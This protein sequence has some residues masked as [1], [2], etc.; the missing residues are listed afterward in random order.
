MES[1]NKSIDTKSSPPNTSIFSDKNTIIIILLSLLLLSFLGINLI[2]NI[3]D[4][5]QWILN[6]I[7]YF[8]RP[9]LSDITFI[10]GTVINNSSELASDA[11]KTGIDIADGT[12]Q[13]VGDL[14]IKAG[15]DGP[16]EKVPLGE[17]KFINRNKKIDVAINQPSS[18]KTSSPSSDSTTN[19]I[20]K[21][22]SSNKAGWC[23]IDE[24]EGQRNCVS[25][26][27]HEKCMSGQIFQNQQMCLHP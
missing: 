1:A 15:N 14:V 11:S 26:T 21:P 4:I 13:S 8:F 3:G 22:I 17:V 7:V 9:L 6:S 24:Y 20:Q 5:F 25:I 23:L 10:T 27:E 2:Q 18:V 12:L 19:P 16:I